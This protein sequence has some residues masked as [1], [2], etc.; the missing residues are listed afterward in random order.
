MK[1]DMSI[2][3]IKFSKSIGTKMSVL[4]VLSLFIVISIFSHLNVKLT[5]KRLMEIA[6]NS[7]TQL[8]VSLSKAI[9]HA[10]LTGDKKTIQTIIDTIS[11]DPMLEDIKI[12]DR[13]GKVKWAKITN[14]ISS[15]IDRTKIKSCM[16]CHHN[17]SPS[18]EPLS[19]VFEKDTGERVLR[20]VTIIDNKP[21]CHT[22]HPPEVNV[23]GKLLVDYSVRQLDRIVFDN[24]KLLIASAVATLIS[25]SVITFILLHRLIGSPLK[26][27]LD[28]IQNVA[29]G[30]LNVQ[31]QIKGK[32]E[33]ALL[34]TFFNDMVSGIKSY[35]EREQ[36][37]HIEERLT[38]ASVADILNKSQ[39]TEEATNLILNT[40]NI[41][42]SVEKCA[43]LYIDYDGSMEV[44]G[45]VGL[46]DEEADTFK[47]YMEIAFNIDDYYTIENLSIDSGYFE[48]HRIKE[49]ILNGE[50]FVASGCKN[51]VDNF[52]VV[53][54]KIANTVKGAIIVL[55][56]KNNDITSDRVKKI[57]SIVAS[58]IAPHFYIGSCLDEKRHMKTGPYESFIET[59]N[60]HIHKVEQY[61]APLSLCLIHL[62][63]YEA[64]CKLYSPDEAS[65]KIRDFLICLSDAIEKVHELIRISQDKIV[66][67]LP[68]LTKDEAVEV[69]EK[70][71]GI[72]EQDITLEI[73]IKTYP[74]DGQT[75]EQL[76]S[77]LQA[78]VTQ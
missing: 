31:V 54:L 27:I 1:P 17:D 14:E 2:N 12:I 19:I 58:A 18:R 67:I 21:A 38:L 34:G 22:C 75:A 41:G 39:S 60:E 40:L 78:E 50:V 48:V 59:L 49:K 10:M 26:D 61:S 51:L 63:N 24:R 70:T 64:L 29:K 46:T 68:M 8:S 4:L 69:I 56:I 62:R 72:K 42:F 28:K 32:D 37:E 3:K 11:N 74:D 76:L 13:T 71:L 43:I 52:L 5:E 25:V 73:K 44:K 65:K 57:F 15:V 77:L 6:I 35:I 45:T 66:V 9:E 16:I 55:Q 47:N 7:A 30:N 33:M 20:N 53:P 36:K 23:I